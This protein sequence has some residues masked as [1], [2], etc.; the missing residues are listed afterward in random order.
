M[1]FAN[2]RHIL[3]LGKNAGQRDALVLSIPRDKVFQILTCLEASMSKLPV[4]IEIAEYR[5]RGDMKQRCP[6]CGKV[7]CQGSVMGIVRFSD[8]DALYALPA[9]S[10]ISCCGEQRDVIALYDSPEALV[11]AGR[12]FLKNPW[13]LLPLP[14]GLAEEL[15]DNPT[16]P[17][18]RH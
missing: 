4:K 13:G 17:W 2:H 7:L 12:V 10:P 15:E 9:A 18:K 5:T 8:N 11:D 1:N 16:V 6:E 3:H 14:P